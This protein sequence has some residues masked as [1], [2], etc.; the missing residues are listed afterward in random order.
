MSDVDK[1]VDMKAESEEIGVLDLLVTLAESWLAIVAVIVVGAALGYGYASTQPVSL[2]SQMVLSLTAEDSA[3]II[4]EAVASSQNV[5]P[6]Q[7][8]YNQVPGTNI[9]RVGLIA[10]PGENPQATLQRIV[11]ELSSAS[12]LP[13]LNRRRID[14]T[15]AID[16][17]DQWTRH[18]ALLQEEMARADSATILSYGAEAKVELAKLITTTAL[19]QLQDAQ[20]RVRQLESQMPADLEKIVLEAPTSSI[21]VSTTFALRMALV[22]ALASGFVAMVVVLAAAGIRKATA[23]ATNAAKLAR[24]KR[25]FFFR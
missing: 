12:G 14:L 23:D 18:Y 4:R 9:T 16:E 20:R 10:S 17:L 19:P 2:S 6:E 3:L 11:D 15:N 8:T 24:I 13:A 22:S 1:K 21:P 7:F 25:A 5:R